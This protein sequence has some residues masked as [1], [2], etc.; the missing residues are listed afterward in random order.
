MQRLVVRLR[1]ELVHYTENVGRENSGDPLTTMPL[2]DAL[3]DKI[4]LPIDLG[5]GQVNFCISVVA[6]DMC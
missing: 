4:P 2:N 1:L 6:Y 5:E 3:A